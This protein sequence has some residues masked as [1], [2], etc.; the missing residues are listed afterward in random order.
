MDGHTK[1]RRAVR[2]L[3]LVIALCA[4]LSGLLLP[5]A[6]GAAGTGYSAGVGSNPDIT[7][8]VTGSD[9]ETYHKEWFNVPFTA[10]MNSLGK[11]SGRVRFAT[12]TRVRVDSTR[13]LAVT[14][15][16][17][18]DGGWRTIQVKDTNVNTRLRIESRP[19]LSIMFDHEPYEYDP[20]ECDMV[21]FPDMGGSWW[22]RIQTDGDGFCGAIE[23]TAD[24]LSLI[25]I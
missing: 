5:T 19:A 4:A 6:A 10:R 15:I 14:P 17:D 18:V 23:I 8:R 25:H 7:K 2:G 9:D 12:D 24:D 21:N 3:A 16:G 13:D 11:L 22:K 20:N 1:H